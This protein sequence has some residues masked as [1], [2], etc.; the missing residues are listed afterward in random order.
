MDEEGN[1]TKEENYV[2]LYILEELLENKL[3]FTGPLYQRILEK[4]VFHYHQDE[5]LTANMLVRDQDP[6][7]TTLVAELTSDKFELGNWAMHDIHVALEGDQVQRMLD[8]AI[9][10]FKL[11]R[12]VDMI[13]KNQDKLKAVGNSEECMKYLKKQ[14]H[15][16][17]LRQE[18][19]GYF[20]STII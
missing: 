3:H 10:S 16:E 6:E 19:S 1:P 17:S 15:L 4:Y 13:K 20:G 2:A 8:S 7:L 9:N 18:L 12:V 14:K 11:R 5:L